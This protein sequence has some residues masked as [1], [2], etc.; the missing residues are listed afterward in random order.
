MRASSRSALSFHTSI[1]TIL[2]AH[3]VVLDGENAASVV[4]E[5][6]SP[7]LG[8]KNGRRS[9]SRP[10][11]ALHPPSVEGSVRPAPAMLGLG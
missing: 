11:A 4:A 7:L 1:C 5:I 8:L 6:A 2:P 9:F 3:L 10:R